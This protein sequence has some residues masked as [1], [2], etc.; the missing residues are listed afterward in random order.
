MKNALIDPR[1]PTGAILFA[2]ATDAR[3][4]PSSDVGECLVVSDPPRILY[5]GGCSYC[6]VLRVR[7]ADGNLDLSMFLV[8]ETSASDGST[9][10][11]P[12]RR[13]S[14]SDSIPLILI[15]IVA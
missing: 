14:S 13:T 10:E 8:C 12:C 5:I 3:G 6:T 11:N 1:R 4:K 7:W 15:M 2:I 9:N